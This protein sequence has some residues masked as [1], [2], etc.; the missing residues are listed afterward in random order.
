MARAAHGFTYDGRLR[1]AEL[2]LT[3]GG[4]VVEIRRAETYDDYIAT[5]RRGV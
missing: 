5:V 2:M 1:P 4:D 3:G